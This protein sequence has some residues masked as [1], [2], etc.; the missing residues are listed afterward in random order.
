MKIYE[1]LS[2]ND[3]PEAFNNSLSMIEFLQ[4]M[5]LPIPTCDFCPQPSTDVI[6]Q[7]DTNTRQKRMY[8][9]CG[10]CGQ[11]KKDFS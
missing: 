3:T 4:A 7:Y 6:I 2:L 10:C 11:S 8:T 5:G 1:S 9:V